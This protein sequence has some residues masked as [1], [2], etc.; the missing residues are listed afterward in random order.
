MGLPLRLVLRLMEEAGES[1]QFGG[2]TAAV[3]R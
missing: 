1:Y 3:R 2:T